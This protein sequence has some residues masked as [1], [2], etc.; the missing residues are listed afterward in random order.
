M[1]GTIA[2]IGYGI[3]T[4]GPA[5]GIGMLVGKT[6]EATARQPE[7]AGRLFT[8]M[9]IGAALVEALGLI[10]FAMPFVVQ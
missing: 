8:N 3:A 2:Y 1:T 4:L 7:V 6:Q 9:I 10:G 5:L